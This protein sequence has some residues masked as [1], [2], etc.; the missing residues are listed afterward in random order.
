MHAG[1]DKYPSAPA[2]PPVHARGM[3]AVGGVACETSPHLS[4]HSRLRRLLPHLRVNVRTATRWDHVAVEAVAACVYLVY[5]GVRLFYL[6]SGRLGAFQSVS[7]GYSLAVLVAEALTGAL[8]FYRQQL[9][10][11]Q[12][13]SFAPMEA[14]ELRD[15]A[16]VCCFQLSPLNPVRGSIPQSP[17]VRCSCS[18]SSCSRL[19][20]ITAPPAS[21]P[22]R[23]PAAARRRILADVSG[24]SRQGRADEHLQDVQQ[25]ASVHASPE[26]HPWVPH[27]L[28]VSGV[29]KQPPRQHGLR[30]VKTNV[31]VA[32]R[33]SEG[34]CSTARRL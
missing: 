9:F 8:L 25:A 30:F 2:T 32:G 16:E 29:F 7:T 3:A 22:F 14:S 15:L 26:P 11:K 18:G 1:S 24:E 6:A 28:R 17:S 4:S 12:E 20:E 5:I 34:V 19:S 10:W 21:S 27:K 23:W 31:T 33:M 13:A